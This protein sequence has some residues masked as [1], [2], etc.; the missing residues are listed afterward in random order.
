MSIKGSRDRTVNREEYRK[1]IERIKRNEA[2]K[3]KQADKPK[4]RDDEG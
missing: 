2:R 1:S 4:D 3:R